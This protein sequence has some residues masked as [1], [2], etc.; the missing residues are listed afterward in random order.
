[1]SWDQIINI[2]KDNLCTIGSHTKNH[3]ALNRL[4]EVEIIDEIMESNKIIESKIGKKI[5]HFSYPFGSINEAA[6]REFNIIKKLGFK[7]DGNNKIW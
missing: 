1:M 3:Y 4:L 2:S 7:T 5:E 6:Q